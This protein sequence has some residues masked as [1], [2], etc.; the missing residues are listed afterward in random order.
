MKN[1]VLRI[2]ADLENVKKLYC[3]NDFLWAF[4]IKDST[5]SLTRENIQFRKTDILEI[6]NSRGTA[7]FMVKWTEYPK[8][9]TINFVN[10][11]NSCSYD[12]TAD[13]DWQD[14]AAFECRGIELVEFLPHGNFIVEDTKGK[15][16]YDVNLSDLN[17]CD[18]N[19]D[20]EMCVGIYNVEHEI[21]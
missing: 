7:N 18:Y 16:Y 1:T 9:S 11:K 5:S 14:F 13:N 15:I 6:P 20:H 19:Q 17:W 4:N 12:S 2:K 10:T 8:Y 3:D 21:C